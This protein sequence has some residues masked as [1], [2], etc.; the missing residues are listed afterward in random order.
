MFEFLAEPDIILLENEKQKYEQYMK[1][2]Q[3]TH[4]PSAVQTHTQ[5]QKYFLFPSF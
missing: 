2:T 5:P 1:H 4:Q 3:Q